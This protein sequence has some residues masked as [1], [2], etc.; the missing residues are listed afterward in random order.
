MK[1]VIFTDV[2]QA[3]IM[4]GGIVTVIVQVTEV[5]NITM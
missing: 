1:G 2:F 4:L 3:L 5:N